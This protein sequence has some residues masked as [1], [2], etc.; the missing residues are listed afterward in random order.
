MD[1]RELDFSPAPVCSIP[2]CPYRTSARLVEAEEHG[3]KRRRMDLCMDHAV[4][5]K[6]AYKD[7]IEVVAVWNQLEMED[8]DD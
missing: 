7:E 3:G 6:R 1:K 8:F 5:M 4:N 2:R